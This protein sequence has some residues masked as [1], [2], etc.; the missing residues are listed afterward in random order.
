METLLIDDTLYER[1]ELFTVYDKFHMDYLTVKRRSMTAGI[2][3]L[4]LWL[5]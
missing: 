5:L 1:Y 2:V 3:I 4:L